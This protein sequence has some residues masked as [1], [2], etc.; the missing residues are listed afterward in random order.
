MIVVFNIKSITLYVAI[1]ELPHPY[2]QKIILKGLLFLKQDTHN[3]NPIHTV[4]S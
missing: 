4:P 1:W 2:E 3:K